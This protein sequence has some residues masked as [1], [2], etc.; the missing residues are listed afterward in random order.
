MA[1]LAHAAA[2]AQHLNGQAAV[3]MTDAAYQEAL[4]VAE[5]GNLVWLLPYIIFTNGVRAALNDGVAAQVLR[6]CLERA[7][8]TSAVA[9][10]QQVLLLH[11]L[12]A[13]YV[14]AGAAPGPLP[15]RAGFGAEGGLVNLIGPRTARA[16]YRAVAGGGHHLRWRSIDAQIIAPLEALKEVTSR[17]LREVP[18]VAIE[19]AALL[20]THT[21]AILE[22]LKQ[23]EAAPVLGWRRMGEAAAKA[24]AAFVDGVQLLSP[25]QLPPLTPLLKELRENFNSAV[26]RLSLPRYYLTREDDED[27]ADEERDDEALD[28]ELLHEREEVPTI[29]VSAIRPPGNRQAPC[30]RMSE[31]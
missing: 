16:A 10:A 20:E 6:L 12:A 3:A 13:F 17:A 23:H 9:C 11:V 18:D 31:H 25:S 29:T 7:P 26:T 15:K 21:V 30:G 1:A 8:D 4:S 28:V 22:F 2:A 14:P 27:D 5:S 24:A 19:T